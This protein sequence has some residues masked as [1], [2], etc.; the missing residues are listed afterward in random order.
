MAKLVFAAGVPHG[1]RMVQE[2]SEAPG[3]L[4]AEE[5]MKAVRARLEQAEP[6]VIIEVDSDH[7]VNFFLNNMPTFC[8]GMAEEAEGPQEAWCPMPRYTLRGHV[9]LAAGLLRYGV[10]HSFD[11]A[12]A[13]ELRPDH[14]LMVPLHFLNPGMELPVVPL[15]TNGFGSPMPLATRCLA[16]GQ[17]VRGFVESWE[18]NERIALVASGVFAGDVGGPLRGWN[19]EAWIEEIRRHLEAGT[20]DLLAR[21]AT[22]DRINAA[23]NNS[24]ELLNWITVA[25]AVGERKPEF[26]EVDRGGSGYAVWRME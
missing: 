12:A 6:D 17:M 2:I 9:P 14:S 13:H 26:V 3:T 16:L 8:V 4:R 23:G 15:Y 25:G 18:G 1:P 22:E 10:T 7:F 5:L 19:D 21:A 20:Y 11:L 24:G